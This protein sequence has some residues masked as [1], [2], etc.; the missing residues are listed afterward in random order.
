MSIEFHCEHCEKT[1]RASASSA[2]KRGKCPHCGGEIY[3][4]ALEEGE[5]SGELPLAPLDEAEEKK[6]EREAREA[7]ALQRKLLEDRDVPPEGA[8]G[9]QR[10]S[11][12]RGESARAAE[13]APSEKQ[14]NMLVVRYID[15]MS[16]GQLEEADKVA[17][18]LSRHSSQVR[19]ILE[20]IATGEQAGLGL[21]QLP[22]PVLLGFVKQLS[23]RL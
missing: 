4:P 19:S 20:S 2:G 18:K 11:A 15:A 14:L 23:S 5:G 10:G 21:P 6:A 12:R 8:V 22:R 7:K 3:V 9:A 13:P 1:I 17:Q 16:S